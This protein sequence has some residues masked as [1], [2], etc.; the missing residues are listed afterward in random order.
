MNIYTVLSS[1]RH[2]K[3]Y[4]NRYLTFINLR[5]DRILD[6]NIITETH[7]I[8]PR[9]KEMFPEYDKLNK[10]PWNGIK[11]TLREHYIAHLLLYKTF[12]NQ[13]TA[14]ALKFMID[15][16]TSIHKLS[17]TSRLYEELRTIHYRVRKNQKTNGKKLIVDDIE[18]SSITKYA[19]SGNC[20]VSIGTLLGYLKDYDIYFPGEKPNVYFSSKFLEIKELREMNKGIANSIPITI[21]GVLYSCKQEYFRKYKGI[22]YTTL[23]L[24]K[25]I[26]DYKKYFPEETQINSNKFS[27]IIEIRRSIRS[28]SQKN[29]KNTFYNRK[30]TIETK[31]KIS[32]RDYSTCRKKV[33]INE[34]CFNSVN[35]AA[36]H[37]NIHYNTM[38]KILKK[39][40][41]FPNNI[42]E[43]EYL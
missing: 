7:H 3:H 14:M 38:T 30:H 20:P 6:S 12:K 21:D 25:F 24:D 11:L 1:K 40:K 4:L 16:H 26:Q 33:R 8:L 36:Q 2:N 22:Q 5:K 34:L 13:S 27:E 18:Y 23:Q 43:A 10:H 42:W 17:K 39:Q 9:A 32:N 35:E 28:E 19:K 29:H 37:F 15:H 31:T 41:P